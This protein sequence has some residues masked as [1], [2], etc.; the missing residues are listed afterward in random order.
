MPWD[1]DGEE[2]LLSPESYVHQADERGHLHERAYSADETGEATALAT[3]K[4]LLA[5]VSQ[6]STHGH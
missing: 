1:F 4:P 6:E 5:A 2:A 3:N